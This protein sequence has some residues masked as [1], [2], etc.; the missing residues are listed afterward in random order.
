[1]TAHAPELRIL[2][3][4]TADRGDDGAAL[5][6]ISHV[7]PGL[8]EA[9]RRR[10]EIRRCPQLDVTDV[11]DIGDGIACVV[12]DTVIGIEPGEVVTMG[13]A[14]L[15]RRPGGVAPRSSHAL[16]VDDALLIAEACRGSLPAGTFVGIGGKWFG[17]G[18]RFS[19]AVKAGIPAFSSAIQRSIEELLVS[20]PA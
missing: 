4:G 2:V 16:S 10:L 5:V 8:P 14:E 7:L 18:E 6:A 3:C 17:Y 15:A 11:M 12:V 9:I 1:M 20:L 19:R 13:L